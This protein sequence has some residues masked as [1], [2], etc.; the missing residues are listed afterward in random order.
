ML[1]IES[2]FQATIPATDLERARRFYEEMLGLAV[3]STMQAGIVFRLGKGSAFF[4]YPS[5][6]AGAGHTIGTWIVDDVRAAV[7][8][9]R[10]RGIEFEEYDLP[11]LKTDDAV[12]DLGSELAAWFK[13]SEGNILAVAELT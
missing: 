3:E 1:L 7:R 2:E 6:S 9:L 4:L 5:G 12:A 10:A 13:D 11:G 8:D